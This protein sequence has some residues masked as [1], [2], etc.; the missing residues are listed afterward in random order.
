M[1]SDTHWTLVGLVIFVTLFVL[2]VGSTYLKSQVR[3]HAHLAK[4][5][6]EGGDQEE[7]T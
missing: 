7:R 5:P 4:L 3:I 6:L 2:F 1:F